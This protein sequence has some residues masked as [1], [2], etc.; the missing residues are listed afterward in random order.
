VVAFSH[1]TFT[2]EINGLPIF[3]FQ[4][5]RQTEAEE[6]CREWIETSINDLVAKNVIVYDASSS[7]KVRLARPDERASYQS[8]TTTGITPSLQGINLVYLIDLGS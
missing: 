1:S 2:V 8:L 3:V 4:A 5:R 7:V 6:I